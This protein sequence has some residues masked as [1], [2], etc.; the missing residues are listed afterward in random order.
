M[1]SSN[2]CELRLVKLRH[3]LWLKYLYEGA[4]AI[5]VDSLTSVFVSVIVKAFAVVRTH[6]GN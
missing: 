1:F 4:F 6:I 3:H 5:A 2:L